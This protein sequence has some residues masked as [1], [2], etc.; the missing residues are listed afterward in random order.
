MPTKKILV[1][2][3]AGYIGSHMVLCLQEAGYTPIVFDNLSTGHRDAVINA[4]LIVGDIGD[5]YALEDV[6]ATHDFLAVM[7]F[8]SFIQVGESVKDPARYYQNNV[9]AT[10]NLL[11]TM[12][13]AQVNHFIFSSTAAVYGE[14][15]YTPIDEKHPLLPM[16]P[17]G[18]SKRMV[19]Q[20]LDDYSR[21]YD[22]CYS[23]LR[24]FNAAG[25]DPKGRLC[26]RHEPETHLIPLILK[27][28]NGDT[29]GV[30]VYGRDYPTVDGTCVR[31]YIHVNDICQ[32]HLL[33]LKQLTET[34]QNSVYNLG[35][36]HG[37]TVQQVIDAARAV[38]GCEINVLE[39]KRRAGDPAILVADST[40]A[41]TE[42]GWI[43]K[44]SDLTSI[45]K[46]AWIAFSQDEILI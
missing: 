42:L 12:L 34:K 43:P 31:D 40:L 29:D 24:Y 13:K 7:H 45:I 28:A 14:P 27:A 16:N 41:Q 44:H 26:E 2:G 37:Y 23:S 21:A 15:H 3:G 39:G 4:E 9:A 35:N 38:T 46:H 5:R 25:A 33:A 22:L 36:G 20:M 10:I 19:E 11:N 17:Y 6:F 18:H 32:A 8:A 30:T 1:V